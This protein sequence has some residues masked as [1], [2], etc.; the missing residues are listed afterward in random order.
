MLEYIA[1]PSKI[2]KTLRNHF[3]F[4][5]QPNKTTLAR[6]SKLRMHGHL[7]RKKALRKAAYRARS[8]QADIQTGYFLTF[9]RKAQKGMDAFEAL[10]KDFFEKLQFLRRQYPYMVGVDLNDWHPRP[11]IAETENML[12]F[13]GMSDLDRALMIDRSLQLNKN[14]PCISMEVLKRRADINSRV[15]A[16]L[17]HDDDDD[18]DDAPDDI[19]AIANALMYDAHFH[20]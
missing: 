2:L 6:N 14:H 9:A 3:Q 19:K 20:E 13:S 5:M 16:H 10:R 12:L 17:K 7:V 1:P 8:S 11:G 15:H 18:D 4:K